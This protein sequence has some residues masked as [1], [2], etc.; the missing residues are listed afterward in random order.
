MALV[1][2]SSATSLDALLSSLGRDG[3]DFERLAK[4]F[5]TTDPEYAGYFSRVWL[6][7][8][9]PDQWGIDRGID[10]V[11]ERHDGSLVAIQAKNY[12]ASRTIKKRD[13]DS[14]L[15]ESSR[16]VFAERLLI[17]TTDKLAPGAHGVMEEQEK[18][19]NRCLLSRLEES[20]VAWPRHVRQLPSVAPH[21]KH[22]ARPHQ[23]EALAAIEAGLR[24]GDRGQVVMAC[25]TVKSLVALWAAEAQSAATT[26]VLV[27]TIPLL[28][29]TAQVW[30]AHAS[31]PFAAL[32]VCSDRDPTG[33]E[34]GGD[35]GP[36]DVGPGATTDPTDIAAFL[37]GGG[38][39]VV[40]STYNSSPKIAA[41]MRRP[42]VPQFDLAICDEAHRCAGLSAGP[43]KT[44]L[45]DTRIPARKR[46]FFTAT[47]E[48]YRGQDVEHLRRQHVRIHSMSDTET[49]GPVSHKLLMAEA[50]ERKLLCPYQVVFMPVSKD[51]VERL[52][53]ERRQVT[54]DYGITRTDAYSLATQ[55]ACLRAMRTYGCRR[56]VSFHA[57]IEHSRAFSDQFEGA[58]NLLPPHDRPHGE[59]K[60]AHVDGGG[61]AAGKRRRILRDFAQLDDSYRLLSN[62]K[63]VSEG[64]DAPS[65]DAI[66]VIGTERG[67]T[68]IIQMIGRAVRPMEGKAVGTIVL[69]VLVHGTE[70]L[71]EAMARSEHKPI[72]KLLAALRSADP[73]LERSLDNLRIQV[74]ADGRK[75]PPR[76]RFV[77]DV[78]QEVGPDFAEAIDVMLVDTLA[79][80]LRAA[81]ARASR[82]VNSY[83]SPLALASTPIRPLAGIDQE[84]PMDPT[85]I[86]EGLE[87]L[88]S[89]AEDGLTTA[90]RAHTVH[91]GAPLG[92]W[93]TRLLA[94]WSPVLPDIETK[95]KI[96]DCVTWLS[97]IPGDDGASGRVLAQ[98]DFARYDLQ[99]LSSTD[100]VDHIHVFLAWDGAPGT[101]PDLMR[102]NIIGPYSDLSTRRIHDALQSPALTTETH[103]T[104]VSRALHDAG[105]EAQ[106]R[107]GNAE[108]FIDGFLDGLEQY[109]EPCPLDLEPADPEIGSPRRQ[110]A[111][112]WDLARSFR[113]DA[114][115]AHTAYQQAA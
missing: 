3:K 14:F 114:H 5:L 93:W 98:R 29:Q 2:S 48:V 27:P 103:I 70:P 33:G 87:V 34:E 79:P 100:I 1:M 50:I 35:L 99:R 36:A 65:I 63:L 83:A 20:E 42:S 78:A 45:D 110:Y 6:W 115:Q 28:R 4:W 109:P 64:F 61:M 105:W 73:D 54:P 52:I 17:A 57:R 84:G 91:Q 55:I 69:P 23:L 30:A 104:L 51:S 26:L 102:N 43:S 58:L 101:L 25:G 31:T 75:V 41:A 46:L 39:R 94:N 77:L 111:A 113:D 49:F 19:V 12:A 96:A 24:Q 59:V 32:K 82:T 62:V 60:A 37:V 22:Q 7:D 112:G 38:R 21:K 53:R 88:L 74:G 71:H 56:M 15:S 89:Y 16:V 97:V 66:A 9:W 72:L 47:P 81:R 86:S 95:R 10:L 76:R 85:L 68:Q 80:S 8:D 11:G 106:R 67:E 108:M 18:A 90:P 13:L 92:Q 107:G 44:I 40:F